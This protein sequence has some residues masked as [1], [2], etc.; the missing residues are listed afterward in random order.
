MV[1]PRR[2]NPDKKPWLPVMKIRK[3][4]WSFNVLYSNTARAHELGKT[5]DWVVI[6]YERSVR[7]QIQIRSVHSGHR[8]SGS[9]QRNSRGEKTICERCLEVESMEV[10]P[11][12]PQPQVVDTRSA[13]RPRA[14]ALKALPWRLHFLL[15]A[16]NHRPSI[17]AYGAARSLPV[18]PNQ[19]AN[20]YLQR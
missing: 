7:G 18:R 12:I 19:L 15:L 6:N 3:A 13:I 16:D 17:V 10:N 8:I 20:E 9:Q 14:V 1:T 5:H 4:G 11:Q 2:F